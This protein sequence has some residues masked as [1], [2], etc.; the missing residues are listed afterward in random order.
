MKLKKKFTVKD[1]KRFSLKKRA[2]KLFLTA[3]AVLLGTMLSGSVSHA[4]GFG[5]KVTINQN[6][7]DGIDPYAL[8]GSAIGIILGILQLVGIGA[9][10]WGIVSVTQSS[11][12]DPP[13]KKVKGFSSLG[14]G[15]VMIALK[16]VLQAMGIIV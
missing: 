5:Q 7:L 4:Q 9:V 12:D 16:Y 14:A 10:I 3:Q 13:D 2:A 8:F 1:R 6:T 15:I 11:P